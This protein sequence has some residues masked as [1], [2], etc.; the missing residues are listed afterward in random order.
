MA[1]AELLAGADRRVL[2][3]LTKPGQSLQQMRA[4]HMDVMLDFTSWQRLTAFYSMMS[5]RTIYGR[6][7]DGGA[8][9]WTG[10]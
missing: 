8:V 7:S 4:E 6:F 9:S 5:G 2:I 1:A 3:D 10:I